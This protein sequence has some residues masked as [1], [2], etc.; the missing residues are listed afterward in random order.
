MWLVWRSKV[1]RPAK[2]ALLPWFPSVIFSYRDRA[3]YCQRGSADHLGGGT[4][5]PHACAI[6][7]TL[8]NR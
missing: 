2:D 1:R 6:A 3:P 4:L 7:M 8:T 5:K